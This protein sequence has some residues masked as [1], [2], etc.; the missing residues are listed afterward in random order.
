MSADP[1]SDLQRLASCLQQARLSQG[2]SLEDL[3]DRLHM[4]REQLQSLENADS[5]SLPEPVFVI[6]QA[7]RVASTLGVSIDP[8][9]QA[10]RVSLQGRKPAPQPAEASSTPA[11]PQAMTSAPSRSSQAAR[12]PLPLAA[13][14]L[15]VALGGVGLVGY[16][17]LV[18][19]DGGSGSTALAPAGTPQPAAA[20]APESAVG[21]P[22]QALEP[23]G[24]SGAG[25]GQLLLRAEQPSWLEVRS[26]DGTTLFRGT[27]EG[28]QS[29][30]LEADLQ[31]L[32][33]RPDLVE[34]VPPGQPRRLLGTI[35]Q[36]RWQRF[37]APSP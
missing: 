33:G 22:A 15:L 9:I 25:S 13:A 4:G 36:V 10:L 28:E 20:S 12:W 24:A 19:P 35:E 23:S 34:V 31:V 6:A 32:A 17:R 37:R 3:A 27:L 2:L 7:R 16:Q 8:E 29:F 11:Q 21:G 30:P 5:D 18:A 26:A 1:M 14:G